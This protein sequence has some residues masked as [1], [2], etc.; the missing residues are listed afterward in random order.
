M[1]KVSVWYNLRQNYKKFTIVLILGNLHLILKAFHPFLKTDEDT[2]NLSKY[3]VFIFR[4]SNKF[5]SI[6]VQTS[7]VVLKSITW[8]WLIKWSS[9]STHNLYITK[10]LS[11]FL[12]I[13]N[14]SK[15]LLTFVLLTKTSSLHVIN[16]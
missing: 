13:I 5:F 6:L 16:S 11:Q 1:R 12:L 2:F 15:A 8:N 14:S 7:Q 10:M 3:F 9:I 4:S